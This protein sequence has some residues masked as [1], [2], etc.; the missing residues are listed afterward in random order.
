LTSLVSAQEMNAFFRAN[1]KGD[2]GTL[3]NISLAEANHIIMKAPMGEQ[4]LR[5][6]GFI[7]DYAHGSDI[8]FKYRFPSPLE[9]RNRYGRRQNGET[10]PLSRC[11]RRGDMGRQPGENIQPRDS[12][13]RPAKASLIFVN[14]KLCCQS[15]HPLFDSKAARCTCGRP[16]ANT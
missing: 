2:R 14:R 4:N 12:N 8:Q 1:F 5:P 7:S 9:R 15:L 13:L 6:G 11:C 3:P 10:R 16:Y